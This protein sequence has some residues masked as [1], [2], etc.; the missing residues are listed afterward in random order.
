MDYRIGAY[1][2]KVNSVVSLDEGEKPVGVIQVDE[3]MYLVTVDPLEERKLPEEDLEQDVGE[4]ETSKEEGK[5]G[6]EKEEE[7][8]GKEPSD[9]E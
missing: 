7:G 6:D 2:C 8:E 1:K 4:E 5:R 3:W 9:A